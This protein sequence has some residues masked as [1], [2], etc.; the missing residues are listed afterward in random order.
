[1]LQGLFW[2]QLSPGNTLCY[3]WLKRGQCLQRP[4]SN[5]QQQLVAAARLLHMLLCDRGAGV[6][7]GRD[8][9]L[10]VW[11]HSPS[12]KKKKRFIK[13][14]KDNQWLNSG[15]MASW[16]RDLKGGREAQTAL[17]N[18]ILISFTTVKC[19]FLHLQLLSSAYR[20]KTH[21]LHIQLLEPLCLHGR[22]SQTNK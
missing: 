21:T 8:L 22:M 16:K 13:E 17:P 7:A 1:M 9:M 6:T 5:I 19:H 12:K 20:I 14:H 3:D 11:M 18:N 2:S 4:R 15:H 10:G